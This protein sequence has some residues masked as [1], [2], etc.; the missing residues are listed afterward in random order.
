MTFL[1]FTDKP[2][3][4]SIP[5]ITDT[6]K[7]SISLAWTRPVEDGGAD[8]IGYILEMQELGTDQWIKTHEKTLRIT[9]Y[10]VIGLKT[11]SK[12]CFRVAAVNVNGAG[13]FSGPCTEVEPVERI[14][15]TCSK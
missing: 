15:K 1:S 9:E 10:T 12:Y 11:G 13:D 2:D 3:A 4:P 5:R 14:G 6:H 7:D 8:V